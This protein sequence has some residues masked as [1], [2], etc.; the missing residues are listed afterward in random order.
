MKILRLLIFVLLITSCLFRPTG[1]PSQTL[2]LA[3]PHDLASLDPRNASD[4]VSLTLSKMLFDG[5]TRINAE[6]KPELAVASTVT[7]SEDGRQY[8]FVLK[9]THWSN[10][11]LVT[12][13]AFARTWLSMLAPQSKH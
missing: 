2:R 4:I 6:G 13:Q 11:D 9:E 3:I 5:L 7:V 10:G 12:A 8:T 1:E